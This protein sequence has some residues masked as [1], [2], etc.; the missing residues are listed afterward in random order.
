MVF[1]I[2]QTLYTIVFSFTLDTTGKIYGLVSWQN[3]QSFLELPRVSYWSMNEISFK[4]L[5]FG[6]LT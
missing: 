1:S 5:L 4:L 6:L 2:S 3:K